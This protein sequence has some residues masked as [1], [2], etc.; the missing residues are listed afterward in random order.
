MFSKKLLFFLFFA[1]PLF[2]AGAQESQ[3]PFP[4]STCFKYVTKYYP[5]LMEGKLEWSHQKRFFRCIEDILELLV[6]KKIFVHDSKRDHFT[7]EEIVRLLH[8][9]YEY[10]KDF[11]IQLADKVFLIKKALI[12][13][14]INQLKDKELALLYKLIPDYREIYFIMHKEIPLLRKVFLDKNSSITPEEKERILVQLK[15]AFLL[16]KQAYQKHRIVYSFKDMDQMG[17]YIHSAQ[18]IDSKDKKSVNQ[19]FT[20][21]QSLLEGLFFP[22]KAIRADDWNKATASLYESVNLFLHYKT[23]FVRG[24]TP[25][26]FHFRMLEGSEIFLS[27]LQI[28]GRGKFPLD[29]LDKMLF[30][31]INLIRPKEMH[32]QG[33]SFLLTSVSNPLALSFLTRTLFCFSLEKADQRK[34]SS[35]W[36]RSSSSRIVRVSFPDSYFEIYPKQIKRETRANQWM[37]ID[38][39]KVRILENWIADYKEDILNIYGREAFHS[40]AVRRQFD[41]WLNSFLSLGRDK[42][43]VFGPGASLD[44]K[45]LSYHFLNYQVFLPLLLQ[46]HV[47]EN[48]F[49]SD[50]SADS[51]TLTDWKQ[52]VEDFLPALMVLQESSENRADWKDSFMSLFHFADLFLY[53]SN[54]DSHLSSR[55]LVDLSIHFME[56][57]KT[58]Q[59]TEE[60]LSLKGDSVQFIES[61]LNDRDIMSVYP[62]FHNHSSGFEKDRY[63]EKMQG[64]FEN[65]GEVSAGSLL[66]IFLLIQAGEWNYHL[67]DSNQSHLLEEEEL[68]V[69][70]DSFDE[71]LVKWI[72]HLSNKQQARSYLMYSLKEGNLPFFT[73]ELPTPLRY[74][75]WH[76]NKEERE[77]FSVS[78]EGFYFF[79][80]DVYQLYEKY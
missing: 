75:N 4:N 67:I 2:S 73:G 69:F 11:S 22:Q 7:K 6:E 52:I 41:H 76:L 45:D 48:F 30:S 60:R 15:K 38:Q 31:L 1:L 5:L 25:P 62:Q 42:R 12:G 74:L 71:L 8:L 79:I 77:S 37:F 14:S 23:Y 66:P 35:R 19:S 54:Q 39:R 16:L 78:P 57:V 26:D 34:C 55:E 10:D 58:L 61:L 59:K 9:Y 29:K 44:K 3:S 68:I 24:M 20:Y 46:F 40:T 21:L 18:W 27:S 50:K 13:G 63:I 36:K 65:K 33:D 47:P 53:S 43:L 28:K 72:P 80:F 70:V 32:S 49:S 51:L 17:S 56:G 64:F